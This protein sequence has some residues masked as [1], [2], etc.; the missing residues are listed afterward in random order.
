[1]LI[2][3]LFSV[4]RTQTE[5]E[6]WVCSSLCREIVPKDARLLVSVRDAV[7]MFVGATRFLRNLLQQ[8]QLS[9]AAPATAASSLLCRIS[10]GAVPV[11]ATRGTPPGEEKRL[12][13]LPNGTVLV[14]N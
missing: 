5:L 6:V 3:N 7:L 10:T 9:S 8:Q 2:S 13:V 1:M 4:I 11:A 14:L 12:S